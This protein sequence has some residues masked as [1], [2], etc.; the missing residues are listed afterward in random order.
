[1][2]LRLA[3]AEDRYY[4][5][6]QTYVFV[7]K[8]IVLF[9]WQLIH[10]E[11]KPYIFYCQIKFLEFGN[12]QNFSRD[13]SLSTTGLEEN[14]LSL[15]DLRDEMKSCECNFLFILVHLINIYYWHKSFD[16]FIKF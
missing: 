14:I 1:M 6:I 9:Y 2:S 7:K 11:E 10:V 15:D 13:H 12:P 5:L 3:V 4:I 8:Y 16:F